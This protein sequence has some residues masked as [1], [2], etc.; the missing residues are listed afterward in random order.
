MVSTSARLAA[1]V[2]SGTGRKQQVSA[3]LGQLGLLAHAQG[4]ASVDHRSAIR[5]PALVSALLK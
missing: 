3:Q 2:A 4:V 5:N 1:Q